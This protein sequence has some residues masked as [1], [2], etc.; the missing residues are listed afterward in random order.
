MLRLNIEYSYL[1]AKTQKRRER[2]RR[3]D[4]DEYVTGN[5]SIESPVEAAVVVCA[6]GTTAAAAAT[7]FQSVCAASPKTVRVCVHGDAC[8]CDWK[9]C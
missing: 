4:C 8:V 7:A 3:R 9:T 1:V 2:Q 6:S 5:E